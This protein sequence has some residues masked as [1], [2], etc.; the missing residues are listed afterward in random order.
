MVVEIKLKEIAPDEY[1]E[2]IVLMGT[3]N[4]YKFQWLDENGQWH[5]VRKEDLEK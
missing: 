5:D 4:L 3:D 1:A 2:A